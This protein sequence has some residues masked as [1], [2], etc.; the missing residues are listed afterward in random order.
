VITLKTNTPPIK[1][2]VLRQAIIIGGDFGN[3]WEIFQKFS[4]TVMDFIRKHS[5]RSNKMFFIVSF[6][7]TY[8]RAQQQY[9]EMYNLA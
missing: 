5:K 3:L 1:T 9:Q 7:Y 8:A 6:S 2:P 4:H